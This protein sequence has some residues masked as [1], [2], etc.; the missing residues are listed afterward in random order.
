VLW[1][2]RLVLGLVDRLLSLRR[3]VPSQESL[4]VEFNDGL[5][6]ACSS[7]PNRRRV[8]FDEESVLENFT[9]LLTGLYLTFSV[10]LLIPILLLLPETHTPESDAWAG[11]AAILVSPIMGQALWH[12]IVNEVRFRSSKG[13]DWGG[14][15]TIAPMGVFCLDTF[16][17]V[18]AW[19]LFK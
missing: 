2:D 15:V 6:V 19:L 11:V 1:L 7:S 9:R 10:L 13:D 4:L 16:L 5:A 14:V 18:I 17:V 8:W 3:Q 12:G